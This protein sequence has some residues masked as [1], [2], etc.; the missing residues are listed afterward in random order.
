MRPNILRNLR[1]VGVEDGGFS[2]EETQTREALL[3]AV[4]ML[5]GTWIYKLKTERITVDG[6]DATE[7]LVAM[8]KNWDFDIVMLAGVSFAGFNL[9]DPALVYKKFE[10]PVVVVVRNKP[11]NV[12]V[13]KA[14]KEHFEDWRI[15]WEVFEKL[16]PI[17][18]I[19]SAPNEPPIY[20]ETVGDEPEWACR[21]VQASAA[22]CR[23]PEPVR[24]ARL[25]ARGLTLRPQQRRQA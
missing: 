25:I 2:K 9:V 20:V 10:K 12:A 15:R 24:V 6:L 17:R 3:V 22:F 4:M 5:E 16:G 13:K 11:N 14:L 18:E 19:V 23:V 7:K 8:L 1:V 21:V